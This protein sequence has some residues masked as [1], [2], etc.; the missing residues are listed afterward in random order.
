MNTHTILASEVTEGRMIGYSRSINTTLPTDE[1]EW[2]F[3]DH[4]QNGTGLAQALAEVQAGDTL[5]IEGVDRLGRY[6][7]GFDQLCTVL[8]EHGVGLAVHVR[9]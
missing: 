4:D 6:A 8:R 2:W 7:G 9:S 1:L 3:S 5:L